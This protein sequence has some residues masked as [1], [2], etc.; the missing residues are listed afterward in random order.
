M[1][2]GLGG[3]PA[4]D[5]ERRFDGYRGFGVIHVDR[6][7]ASDAAGN[8]SYPKAT[9]AGTGACP[10]RREP[11]WQSACDGSGCLCSAALVDEDAATASRVG[12]HRCREPV[13]DEARGLASQDEA[14]AF[15]VIGDVLADEVPPP[16]GS[17]A[18]PAGGC[19]R[20]S[21]PT[22]PAILDRLP[23]GILVSRD[24]IAIY[25]NRT[26]LDLLGFADEDAFHA[27][28]GMAR[29]FNLAPNGSDAIGVGP[30]RGK[31]C[32]RGRAS[33]RSNGIICR[34]SADLAPRG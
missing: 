27:A 31:S 29:M 25:A 22:R 17:P 34:D 21:M 24:N 10:P 3:L 30:R 28:G 4:F 19:V 7:A 26:L 12:R 16:P 6:L 8:F 5:R 2:V 32:R 23:L 33:R 14:T 20:L 18:E 1:P 15:R 13:E 9:R 11:S